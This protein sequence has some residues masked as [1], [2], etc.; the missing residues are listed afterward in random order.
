MPRPRDW[1]FRRGRPS[2]VSCALLTSRDGV[3]E[4]ADALYR[5]NDHV[6]WLQASVRT[7]RGGESGRRARGNQVARRECDVPAQELDDLG[8]REAHLRRAAVLDAIAVDRAA[9]GQVCGI[10]LGCG[11]DPRAD[12]AEAGHRLPEQPLVAIEPCIARRNVVDDGVAKDAAVRS[13]HDAQ[14]ALPVDVVSQ[15]PIPTD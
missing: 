1:S 10:E 3:G 12:R 11:N 5:A 4:L 6:A 2:T 7:G 14:L 15:R 9:D 8:Y 13:D